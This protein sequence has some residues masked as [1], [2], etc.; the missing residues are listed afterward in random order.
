MKKR[1][2]LLCLF[3]GASAFA[4]PSPFTLRYHKGAI[5]VYED[6]ET[7]HFWAHEGTFDVYANAEKQCSD[8]GKDFPE[9]GN[10]A[11]ELPT[12]EDFASVDMTN[13]VSP[14][15]IKN[16][17]YWTRS[18]NEIGMAMVYVGKTG[19]TISTPKRDTYSPRTGDPHHHYSNYWCVS[20]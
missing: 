1:F 6:L 3:I 17:F 12:I 16:E 8:I 11:W 15:T 10:L 9:T 7:H 4:Q 13:Q 18:E 19:E 14:S 5:T 20:Y 2:G